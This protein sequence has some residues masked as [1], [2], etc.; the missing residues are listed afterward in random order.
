LRE[1]ARRA[2]GHDTATLKAFQVVRAKSAAVGAGLPSDS[3]SRCL[4]FPG[5]ILAVERQTRHCHG[6]WCRRL[7]S[8]SRL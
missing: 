4:L 8:H 2:A 7:G 5:H 6:P 1:P 3:P